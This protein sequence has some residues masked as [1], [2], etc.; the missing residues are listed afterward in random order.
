MLTER[1]VRDAKSEGKAR[2]IWD[3]EVKGLGL[4]VTQGGKK[5]YVIRYTAGG[6]K[7]QAILARASETSLRDIRK[8]AGEELVRIRA[9]ETDPLRRKREELEAPTVTDLLDRFFNDYVPRR[10][11]A[12]R[13][14]ERTVREYTNQRR[15][16]EPVLGKLKVSDVDRQ[17]IER[18]IDRPGPT[19]R[20][21]LAAFLSNLFNRAEDWELRPQHT[22]PARRIEKAKEEPRDRT[23]N[24]TELAGLARALD[25]RSSRFPAPVAAIRFAAITG[26]RIGEVLAVR[27][28]EVDFEAGRLTMPDTKTGRRVHDL[29]SAAVEILAGLPRIND[30]CFTTGRDAPVTYR[31]VRNVFAAAA[32]E[33]GLVDVR[34]HDLRR[35]VMI[36]AAAAGVGTHVLRDLLGHRTTAMADRYIRAVG[37]P[38]RDAREQVGAAMAAMMAGNPGEVVPMERRRG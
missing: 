9:G 29:P 1:I 20:N 17:D 21:R 35:T 36:N 16:V 4:Q 13:L 34:L 37:N 19:H 14:S 15:Y 11:E 7:H 32:K 18:A 22:N 33:A 12:G 5:N 27:W 23:L 24:P 25:A 2:T 38:V 6:R 30:W 8:R 28:P 3:G 31:H 10:V 26:L